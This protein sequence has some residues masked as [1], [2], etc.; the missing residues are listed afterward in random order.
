MLALPTGCLAAAA[1]GEGWAALAALALTATTLAPVLP[2]AVVCALAVI[3]A[4]ASFWS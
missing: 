4:A 3:G 2:A 1:L